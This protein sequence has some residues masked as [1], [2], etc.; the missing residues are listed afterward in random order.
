MGLGEASKHQFCCCQLWTGHS[1]LNLRANGDLTP[2]SEFNWPPLKNWLQLCTQR[3][4]AKDQET[5]LG[6]P[7]SESWVYTPQELGGRGWLITE[8]ELTREGEPGWLF[9]ITTH[10]CSLLHLQPYSLNRWWRRGVDT[11]G[12]KLFYFEASNN[13]CFSDSIHYRKTANRNSV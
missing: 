2:A 11:C 3:P 1:G 4:E 8:H 7:S 9:L 6:S 5:W 12:K 10:T 13:C